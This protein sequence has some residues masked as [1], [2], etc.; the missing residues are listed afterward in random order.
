MKPS[1]LQPYAIAAI[2]VAAGA[3]HFAWPG[4]YEKIVPPYLPERRRLVEIS[5]LFEILGGIGA[6]VPATRAP[7]G[8][9]LIAL[10]I[11]VFPANVYM[12]TDAARFP[13]IPVWALWGRLPLQLLLI[14]WIYETL[15]RRS[16]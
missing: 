11:A 3:A 1:T 9:G 10:L 7:A 8:W 14:R 16:R 13:G 6:A 4:V 12:A 5:G 2:F 15:V